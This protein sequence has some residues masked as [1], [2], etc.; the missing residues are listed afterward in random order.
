MGLFFSELAREL[1]SDD[2][3][4]I[5]ITLIKLSRLTPPIIEDHESY[6]LIHQLLR[7]ISL[8]THLP[9]ANLS[10]LVRDR[11]DNIF[12]L[13]KFIS[14]KKF[15]ECHTI[16]ESKMSS[17]EQIY[18]ALINSSE[19]E[20][21]EDLKQY[22]SFLINENPRIRCAALEVYYYHSKI[23]NLKE[24]VAML[25]DSDRLVKKFATRV[26]NRF[27]ER[28]VIKC[29][30]EMVDSNEES[31]K[32][33]AIHC[34][35]NLKTS[36]EIVG[37]LQKCSLPG[38]NKVRSEAIRALINHNCEESIDL[39]KSLQNDM[40]IEIC[41]IA[42]SILSNLEPSSNNEAQIKEQI[43]LRANNTLGQ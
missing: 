5:K 35:S 34:L 15:I 27:G 13:R 31:V 16:L 40:S 7:D 30:Q 29:L 19:Y 24:V 26:L 11:L 28:E 12:S 2:Q 32:I 38:S 22:Q 43:S 9:F 33:S 6:Y 25:N 23:T 18:N 36:K 37:M 4:I 14:Q 41:E 8:S 21:I 42:H 10:I 1:Q 3:D 20:A 39:L 17:T